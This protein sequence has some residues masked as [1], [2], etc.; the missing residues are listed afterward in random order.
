MMNNCPKFCE[1]EYSLKENCI[2]ITLK[3]LK[4]Y[5]RE[6]DLSRIKTVVCNR[7][8]DRAAR[9]RVNQGDNEGV[10]YCP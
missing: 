4:I 3:T 6:C 2:Y 8:M 5:N 7:R 9:L 1:T 10:D